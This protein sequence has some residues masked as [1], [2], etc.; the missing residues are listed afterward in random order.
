MVPF[1]SSPESEPS[2]HPI[3][4]SIHPSIIITTDQERGLTDPLNLSL[5][6][7]GYRTVANERE[8]RETERSERK[9]PS[10]HPPRRFL[11]ELLFLGDANFT[12]KDI[13]CSNFPQY[14]PAAVEEVPPPAAKEWRNGVLLDSESE[15]R[16]CRSLCREGTWCLQ[17]DLSVR[18]H[19]LNPRSA[20]GNGPN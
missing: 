12:G 6:C 2:I 4:P 17:P 10:K 7:I 18:R 8:R 5:S 19:G 3:H 16:L 13:V 15:M 1:A 11:T 20:T 9:T 14:K